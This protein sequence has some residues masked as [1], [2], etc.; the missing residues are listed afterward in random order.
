MQ[1]IFLLEKNFD[2]LNQIDHLY[3]LQFLFNYFTKKPDDDKKGAL[4]ALGIRSLKLLTNDILLSSEHNKITCRRHETSME[5]KNKHFEAKSFDLSDRIH[6]VNPESV[7][8]TNTV[9]SDTTSVE[10]H[11]R[12]SI[13]FILNICA[14]RSFERIYTTILLR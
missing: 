6:L 3:Q 2:F 5:Q 11:P 14:V 12:V 4:V 8:V 9:I 7:F 13:A 10:C 1:V